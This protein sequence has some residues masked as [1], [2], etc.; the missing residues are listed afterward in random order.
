MVGQVAALKDLVRPG[1]TPSH[2]T[3]FELSL[4][5]AAETCCA[6][7]MT[8]LASEQNLCFI[9]EIRS[10]WHATSSESIDV[11]VYIHGRVLVVSKVTLSGVNQRSSIDPFNIQNEIVWMA[12]VNAIF[13]NTFGGGSR[14]H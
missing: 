7:W 10:F 4:P 5:P 13:F 2:Y 3:K 8:N 14:V 12:G 6:Y 9:Q 1:A 11:S